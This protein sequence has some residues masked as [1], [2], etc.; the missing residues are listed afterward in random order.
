MAQATYLRPFLLFPSRRHD[1]AIDSTKNF[2]PRRIK[3]LSSFAS[4]DFEL[5]FYVVLQSHKK[6]FR[7]EDLVFV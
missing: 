3:L 5:N 7:P 4:A 1:Q 2:D 6:N